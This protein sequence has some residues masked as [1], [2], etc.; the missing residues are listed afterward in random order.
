[1]T[2]NEKDQH[3]AFEDK[4]PEDLSAKEK[5]LN[6][7]LKNIMATGI[8]L[9]KDHPGIENL[10]PTEADKFDAL[11]RQKARRGG[12]LTDPNLKD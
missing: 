7:K 4:E 3:K 10:S 1:M 12:K 5:A 6:D 8:P 2:E 11:Q 9:N